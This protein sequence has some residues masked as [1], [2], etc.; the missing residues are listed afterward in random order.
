MS[1]TEIDGASIYH[2]VTGDAGSPPLFLVH[3]L[4]GDSTTVQDLATALAARFRVVAPDMLGHGRSTH[5]RHFTLADQGRALNGL[6]AA[7]GYDRAVLV[8]VSMGSYVAA[9]AAVLEPDRVSRLVLVVPK[10]HGT[11]SSSVAYAQR[12]GFDLAAATPE[13]QLSFMAGAVWS[14]AT[15][16][17]RRE[18]IMAS[19]QAPDQ[20]LL[21][22]DERAA[23]EESLAGFDLRPDLA[24]ITA[25]TLVVSGRSDGLN[26]PAAGEELARGVPGARFEVYESSGHM[27]SFEERDRLV[28]DVIGFV[29]E[30]PVGEETTGS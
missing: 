22:V 19:A 13:E 8:G 6:V 12:M 5:P 18:E 7:L 11:S 16:A 10:A 14:P 24:R 15:S 20:V 26:P 27:L 17:E 3:G 9:Q 25:P 21:S 29:D 4:Y 1:T 30:S 28:A 2:R 23:V